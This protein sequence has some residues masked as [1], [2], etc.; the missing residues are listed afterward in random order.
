MQLI[1]VYIIH[2]ILYAYT[3]IYLYI[4]YL[5]QQQRAAAA[6]KYTRVSINKILYIIDEKRVL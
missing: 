2:S 1:T 4:F 5:Q 6:R 3:D